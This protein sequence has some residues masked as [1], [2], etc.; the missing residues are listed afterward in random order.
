MA[1][2]AGLIARRPTR[3][4]RVDSYRDEF[5]WWFLHPAFDVNAVTR[6][7]THSFIIDRLFLTMSQL[8]FYETRCFGKLNNYVRIH[9]RGVSTIFVDQCVGNALVLPVLCCL[10]STQSLSPT[11]VSNNRYHALRR[12]HVTF[13]TGLTGNGV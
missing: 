12:F 13:L 6:R 9:L 7:R 3:S 4:E 1:P 11:N 2:L 8:L 10:G 5:F